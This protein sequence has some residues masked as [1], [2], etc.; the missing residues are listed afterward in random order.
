[1]NNPLRE[2]AR[3]A[4]AGKLGTGS[5][6]RNA[7][8][9]VLNWTVQQ[10]RK[11][12]KEASWESNV[13]RSFYKM[14]LQWLL[15]EMERGAKVAVTLAV[16]D[17]GVD[18]ALVV[19]PQLVYRL[20]NK[21]LDVKHIAKYAP[22]IL[23]PEGPMAR[24]IFLAREKDLARERAKAVADD[25]DGLFKCRKCKST[26]TVYYQMQTRSADEPMVRFLVLI[27]VII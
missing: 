27:I 26:K 21:D 13:F 2:Y 25:Y 3:K 16:R 24:A 11:I 5:I 4:F 6:S 14:K 7:E 23:W 18:V 17:G 12:G 15:K 1:M 19:E 22:E 9:S 8:I 20:R 10:T